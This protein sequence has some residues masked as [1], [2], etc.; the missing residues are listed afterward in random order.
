[1]TDFRKWIVVAA[2]AVGSV[3]AADTKL[4]PLSQNPAYS[5]DCESGAVYSSYGAKQAYTFTCGTVTG[6]PDKKTGVALVT[7]LN[8]LE[9]PT[10]ATADKVVAFVKKA[11]P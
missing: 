2:L 3:F 6:Q 7:Q 4:T 1:M 11:L 9:Y 5:I 8:P 10:V